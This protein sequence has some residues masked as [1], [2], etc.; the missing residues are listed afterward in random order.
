MQQQKDQANKSKAQRLTG[1]KEEEGSLSY[2]QMQAD[3][4]GER[5]VWE[6][7]ERSWFSLSIE[8]IKIFV[9][10]QLTFS[11]LNQH[12]SVSLTLTRC[13]W[14]PKY[15]SNISYYVDN[16]ERFIMAL[17]FFLNIFTV[18]NRI[19]TEES[20]DFIISFDITLGSLGQPLT[21]C[22]LNKNTQTE[23]T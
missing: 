4:T 19:C 21:L 12:Y 20:K 9:L 7:W 14:L 10:S 13:F 2:K 5:L 17:H 16:K 8:K 3:K 23:A 1:S 15:T 18:A 22:R 6:V 11:I